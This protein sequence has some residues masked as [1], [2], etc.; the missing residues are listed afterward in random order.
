MLLLSLLVLFLPSASSAGQAICS[1]NNGGMFMPNNTYK[2]NLISLSELLFAS[3]TEEHSAT[4]MAGVGSDKVYGAVLCRGDSDGANCHKRLAMALNEAINSKASGSYSLESSKNVTY[5]DQYQAQISFSD[6]DFLSSFSN[7]PKCTVDTNLNSVTATATERF[8]DLVTKLINALADAVVSRADKYAVGKVWFEETGQT[9]YALAQCIRDMPYERCAVCLD[10][11]ISDR[12]SKISAGQM[13][14]AFLGVWCTLRYETDTQFFTDT[15]MISL[16]ELPTSKTH[17]FRWNNA[18]LVGVGGFLLVLFISCLV[19]HIWINTQRRREQA[20]FKLRRLYLSIQIAINLWRMGGA[21]PEFSLYDFSQIKEATNNFSSGNKL[22]HGGFG[23]VYKGQLRSG[24]KIA[25]KRLETSS[26]QGLL[27]FQ[28]EIQLIAK[29]QHKN[30]V[31]LLGCCTQGDREKMLV[32]EYMENKSLDYFI[33]DM[34]KGARLNWSKRLHIIDGTAQ[35]LLYLHNYSRLC[36]VHRDLKASNILL[37]SVMN[38]KISDFGMARIFCSNMA[39]SSTTRIVGTHG[40]I[41]PEYAFEGVCSIKTDVFSF[42][43]LILEIITGKRTAHFY[44]YNGKLYNLIAYA[45]QLW[46]DGKWDEMIYCPAGNEYHEIERCIHVALLC[47]QE[48]AEDR[49]AMEHVVTMLNTKN[50]SLP[51]PTQPAYFHVNPS[52]EE[53]SSCNNTISITLER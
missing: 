7:V 26:L 39:E 15:K 45:W 5:Y 36:V 16:S 2:S 37:D 41:P 46:I 1:N 52:E 11:I 6:K 24:L 31:K 4:G 21:N 53:V 12:Q 25:V 51:P 10:N 33:F 35:G 17:F 18:V 42:G 13:G 3:A 20:V 40:Y 34:V 27:E 44:L 29:L 22:G 14:A 19:F 9:V 32:Y 8:E 47:V 23:P 49:P 38:P 28:N 48:S 30:L 43:I 50:M